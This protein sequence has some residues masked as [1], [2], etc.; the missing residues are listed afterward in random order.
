MCFL[1][2]L[3]LN[4][5]FIGQV[6]VLPLHTIILDKTNCSSGPA[7]NL[8]TLPPPPEPTPA[9]PP[10][11]DSSPLCS[12]MYEGIVRQ[13]YTEPFICNFLGSSCDAGVNCLFLFYGSSYRILLMATPLADR[14][15][16]YRVL[17]SSSSRVGVASQDNF[18]DVSMLS[19]PDG[20]QLIFS[21]I[22]IGRY[23]T[24]IQVCAHVFVCDRLLLF[25]VVVFDKNKTKLHVYAYV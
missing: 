4:Q 22:S 3:S 21:Q 11:P 14:L 24:R 13:N 18:T 10:S 1:V 23:L 19:S 12:S 15:F 7:L 17:D 9:P 8:T 2:Q 25:F 20:S 16:S 5:F 6:E